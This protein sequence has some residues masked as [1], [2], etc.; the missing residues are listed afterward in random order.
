LGWDATD[1]N[2]SE[3]EGQGPHEDETQ[4]IV[5]FGTPT[6]TTPASPRIRNPTR[7]KFNP[8]LGWDVNDDA[9]SQ[10]EGLESCEDEIQPTIG[11]GRR[12]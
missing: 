5:G 3:V 11:L 2:A 4:L 1:D 6:P 9:A 8:S 10:V 12:P 7:T